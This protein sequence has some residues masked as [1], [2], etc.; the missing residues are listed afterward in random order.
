MKRMMKT[1]ASFALV[2]LCLISSVALCGCSLPWEKK[3]DLDQNCK[4]VAEFCT[5][6]CYYHASGI[7]SFP[8]TVALVIPIG[9]AGYC[10]EM[11]ATVRVGIDASYLKVDD[12]DPLGNVTVHIPQ[13]KILENPLV[14]EDSVRAFSGGNWLTLFDQKNFLLTSEEKAE[15]RKEAENRIR[16]MAEQDDVTKANARQRAKDLIEKSIVELGKSIGQDYKVTFVDAAEDPSERQH[17]DY[18]TTS[19]ESDG[20]QQAEGNG[21]G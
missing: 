6:E 9:D 5:L 13:A 12:P 1:L 4:Y 14:D 2:G 17:Q 11:E 16:D 18:V 19:N 21:Q 15:V 3:I 8:K 20:S 10:V 7:K